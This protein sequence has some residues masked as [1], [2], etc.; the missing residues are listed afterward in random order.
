MSDMSWI[1]IFAVL[2]IGIG[3]IK[4]LLVFMDVTQG[5]EPKVR[6]QVALR[7]VILAGSIGLVLLAFGALLQSILHFSLGALSIAGA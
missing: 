1:D 4:V 5:V 6:R 7:T 3:P 2:F